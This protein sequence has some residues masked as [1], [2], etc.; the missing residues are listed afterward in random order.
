MTEEFYEIEDELGEEP[1]EEPAK[2][3]ETIIDRYANFIAH[4]AKTQNIMR[5]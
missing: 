5:P 2:K 4:Q 3:E 1:A